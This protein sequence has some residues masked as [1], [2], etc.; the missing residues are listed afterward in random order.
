MRPSRCKD[1]IAQPASAQP[2]YPGNASRYTRFP[3]T[4]SSTTMNTGFAALVRYRVGRSTLWQR[5]LRAQ[6]V[7]YVGDGLDD[8]FG[9]KK[10]DLVARTSDDRVP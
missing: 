9:L 5:S 2:R 1:A 8:G 10:M 3:A 6:R 7:E 4:W